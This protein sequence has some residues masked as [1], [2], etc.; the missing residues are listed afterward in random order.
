MRNDE[1]ITAYLRRVRSSLHVSRKQRRRVLEEIE[2]HLDDGAAAHMR[3]GA[4][5]EQAITLVIDELGPADAVAAGFNN[6]GAHGPDVTGA[7]RWLPMLL[8]LFLFMPA[9]GFLI[10]RL[11][12]I[13]GDLT[14][15]E[16]LALRTDL[17]RALMTGALAFAAYFSI[18]R[19]HGDQAWRWAAW[20]CSGLALVMILA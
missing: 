17:L 7:V 6:E 9:V 14:V 20:L 2:D 11:T 4:T 15:G 13:P 3:R 18:R 10:W 8:P 16:R 1:R 5:R 19:A 12:W